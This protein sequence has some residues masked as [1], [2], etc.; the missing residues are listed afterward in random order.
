MIAF[1]GKTTEK[2]AILRQWFGSRR[3]QR[4]F[5]RGYRMAL[6]HAKEAIGIGMKLGRPKPEA[7]AE[8]F[9]EHYE[10]LAPLYGYKT[11]FANGKGPPLFEELPKENRELMVMTCRKVIE[12][13]DVE[14]V[15]NVD[16]ILRKLEAER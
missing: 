2:A 3:K 16:A 1:H 4:E 13:T 12:D 6:R 8:H 10:S 7:L 15:K 9:H 11:R 14:L 5:D